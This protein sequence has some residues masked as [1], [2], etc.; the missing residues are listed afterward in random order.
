VR[1]AGRSP[2][3]SLDGGFGAPPGV[4]EFKQLVVTVG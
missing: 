3:Q 4:N 1:T 2:P